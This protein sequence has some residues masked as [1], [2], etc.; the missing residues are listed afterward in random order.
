MRIVL[1]HWLEL[2]PNKIQEALFR[3]SVGAARF[4]YNWALGEW[5]RQF[6][7][8]EKPNEAALRRQFNAIKPVEFPWI[9]DLPKAFPQQAKCRSRLSAVLSETIEVPA[10]QKTR[11][12][13]FRPVG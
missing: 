7:E 6:A 10:L 2:N 3:Q 11:R 12:S 9:L 8:G 5:Q 4:A 13:R 1:T